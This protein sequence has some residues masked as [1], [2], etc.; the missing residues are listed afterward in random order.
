MSAQ[1]GYRSA[2][3]FDS[4]RSAV[5]EPCS[6]LCLAFIALREL[7]QQHEPKQH[8]I[9]RCL[10]R[11][12]SNSI[13]SGAA[14]THSTLCCA[15]FGRR[16][17]LCNGY[18]RL[19]QPTCN[20]YMCAASL[21]VC[22]TVACMVAIAVMF[23]GCTVVGWLACSMAQRLLYG[24]CFHDSTLAMAIAVTLYPKC[25]WQSLRVRQGA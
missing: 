8:R 11:V 22:C 21:R 20:L 15:S 1:R 16:F 17:L 14:Q 10:L 9:A 23:N 6:L 19:A 4:I 25:N 2:C 13:G 3:C 24:Y 5:W 18:R 12:S 7:H